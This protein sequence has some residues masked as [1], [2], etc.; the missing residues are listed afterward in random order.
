M[1]ARAA[2][3]GSHLQTE[4]ACYVAEYNK[5]KRLAD[6]GYTSPIGELSCFNAEIFC[7]ID[8]ELDKCR[9]EDMRKSHGK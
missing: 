5:R 8:A 2:Y 9:S 4:A 7:I 3:K 6:L 1:Q